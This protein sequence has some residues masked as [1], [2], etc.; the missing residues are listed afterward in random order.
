MLHTSWAIANQVCVVVIVVEYQYLGLIFRLLTVTLV[1]HSIAYPHLYAMYGKYE[2]DLNDPVYPVVVPKGSPHKCKESPNNLPKL[3]HPFFGRGSNMS[4]LEQVLLAGSIHVVGI[5][6]PPGFGKSTLAIHLGRAMV[7]NCFSVGYIDLD[8]EY[9]MLPYIVKSF[10]EKRLAEWIPPL[11]LTFDGFDR[12]AILASGIFKWFKGHDAVLIIDNCNRVL[13]D[14]KYRK[15]FYE[16]LQAMIQSNERGRIVF[17]SDEKLDL[18]TNPYYNYLNFALGNLSLE[19]SVKILR[20]YSPN[21]STNHAQEIA[22]AVE[23]CPIS[24]LLISTLLS[25]DKSPVFVIR[26]LN[27]RKEALK[28]LNETEHKYLNFVSAM[29]IASGFLQKRERTCAMYFSFF[30]RYFPIEAAT[31]I[32]LQSDMKY[33]LQVGIRDSAGAI[34][35]IERLAQKSLLD[36]SRFGEV[37]R[38]KMHRLIKMYF[39]DKGERH[40]VAMQT[41]FNSSFRIYFSELGVRIRPID[42]IRNIVEEELLSDHD[43]HNFNYLI[44]MLL[45]GFR[46]HIYSE[47]ELIYLAFGFHKGLINFDYKLFE[48]LLRLF[49]Y[50]RPQLAK[51]PSHIKLEELSEEDFKILASHFSD[52]FV[53]VLCVVTSRDVCTN[54]YL[55]ILY[56]LYKADKC[57]ETFEDNMEDSCHMVHCDYVDDYFKIL[58]TLEAFQKCSGEEFCDLLLNVHSMCYSFELLLSPVTYALTFFFL[59]TLGSVFL[60]IVTCF[61]V[62]EVPVFMCKHFCLLVIIFVACLVPTYTL[63]LRKSLG[64]FYFDAPLEVHA[65]NVTCYAVTFFYIIFVFLRM[66]INLYRHA[67]SELFS[68]MI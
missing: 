35:S 65:R 5:N 6:G 38:F 3:H 20:H 37:E 14:V 50:P 13:S 30:P 53:N 16:F 10:N 54:V 9:E 19:A 68:L 1:L 34:Y 11:E 60:L 18:I 36:M 22:E 41:D 23:N 57:Y 21:I 7:E 27:S 46:G 32:L 45:L 26:K 59:A 52:F 62:K 66:L 28:L 17:T 12:T 56:K 40:D 47:D 4:Y 29:D 44:E 42:E 43:R 15:Y 58:D 63:T 2:K 67:A 48:T 8:N 49:T 31:K 24:L 25:K 61:R 33:N 55:D 64:R 39:M 51:L